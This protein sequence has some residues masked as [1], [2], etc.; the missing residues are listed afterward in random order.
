VVDLTEPHVQHKLTGEEEVYEL[1]RELEQGGSRY[2]M[3]RRKGSSGLDPL[4]SAARN[5]HVEV[6][7]WLLANADVDVHAKSPSG[8]T[9]MDLCVAAGV[10]GEGPNSP[11]VRISFALALN[12]AG[13]DRALGSNNESIG[14]G[15]MRKRTLNRHI[16]DGIRHA[17]ILYLETLQ[18]H[19]FN[20][21]QGCLARHIS[22]PPLVSLVASFFDDRLAA[23][24]FLCRAQ[25]ELRLSPLDK[26]WKTL[27]D[28]ARSNLEAKMYETHSV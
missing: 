3:G 27:V 8:E 16:E 1:T 24:A 13:T 11:Y 15:T 25:G 22:I 14:R 18:A 6:A 2:H 26:I 28:V 23:P 17:A 4:M 12:G 20:A 19:I 7:L 10:H 9:C 21:P 5:G